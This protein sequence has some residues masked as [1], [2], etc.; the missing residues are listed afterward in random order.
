MNI[1]NSQINKYI[2]IDTT[3][4][5]SYARLSSAKLSKYEAQEKNRAFKMN[6][7]AKKYILEKD[8]K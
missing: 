8:W 7:V 3:A 6:R 1:D 5:A 2:L 4:R